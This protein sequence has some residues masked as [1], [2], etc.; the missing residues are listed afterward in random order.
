MELR[1]TRPI[2]DDPDA[3]LRFAPKT[4]YGF[5]DYSTDLQPITESR[6]QPQGDMKKL[7]VK[8]GYP[9]ISFLFDHGAS[10][11]GDGLMAPLRNTLLQTTFPSL[12]GA[13]NFD[14]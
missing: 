7:L 3:L 13:A 12:S 6:F 2:V 5:P 10:N 11:S 8:S 1:G 9:E 4:W 14:F